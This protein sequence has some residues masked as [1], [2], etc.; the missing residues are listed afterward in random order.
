MA[1]AAGMWALCCYRPRARHR[2][3]LMKC[4]SSNESGK[5]ASVLGPGQEEGQWRPHLMAISSSPGLL[6]LC[7]GWRAPEGDVYR[8]GPWRPIYFLSSHAHPPPVGNLHRPP[9]TCTSLIYHSP[10]TA[11]CQTKW[12]TFYTH[13]LMWGRPG[14]KP[15]QH[16]SGPG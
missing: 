8:A 14:L 4:L 12:E 13:D 5:R 7:G 6:P 11:V 3:A 10:Q 15:S 2:R 16:L 1:G 9:P